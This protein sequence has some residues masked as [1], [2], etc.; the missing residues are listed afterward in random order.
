MTK[1]G[2]THG[3]RA[4][5][6][7][8]QGVRCPRRLTGALPWPDPDRVLREVEVKRAFLVRYEFAA[9]QVAV[10]AVNGDAAEREAWEKIAGALELDVRT[11]TA[12]YSDHPDY[13]P[14]W[15]I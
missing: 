8:W 13:D 6:D 15:A 11:I 12:V 4:M 7:D 9:N 3:A 10:H 14:A 1:T 2:W 5:S